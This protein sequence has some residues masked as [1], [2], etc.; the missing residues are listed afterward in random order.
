MSKPSPVQRQ[1]LLYI[2]DIIDT[3]Y[4][5]PT[6]REI[7][8]YMGYKDVSGT[9]WHVKELARKGYLFNHAKLPRGLRMTDK[10][11][12]YIKEEQ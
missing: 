4:Q 7:Q 5:P 9:T 3:K 10:G 12:A 1:I 8:A 6:R 11:R 2:A